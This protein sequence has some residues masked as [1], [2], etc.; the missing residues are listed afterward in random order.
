[1]PQFP[2]HPSRKY[3]ITDVQ[4]NIDLT[5]VTVCSDVLDESCRCPPLQVTPE[6]PVDLV[7][8]DLWVIN[9]FRGVKIIS[10]CE[11]RTQDVGQHQN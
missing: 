11:A 9:G 1:M 2:Y 5:L 6:G 7:H 8:E 4:L 3:C 10:E